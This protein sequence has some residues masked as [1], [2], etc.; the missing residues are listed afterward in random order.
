MSPCVICGSFNIK[1]DHCG[2][3]AFN[4]FRGECQDCKAVVLA[5]CG[6]MPTLNDLIRIWDAHNT[7]ESRLSVVLSELSTSLKHKQITL[8]EAKEKL[9]EL[10]E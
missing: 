6:C 2:Y 1:L 8:E 5:D 10:S 4:R 9:K 7:Q 3:S